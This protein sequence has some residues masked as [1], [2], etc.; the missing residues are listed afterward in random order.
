MIKYSAT[1]ASGGTE[2]MPYLFK[3]NI[4]ESIE[5]CAKNGFDAVELHLRKAQDIDRVL[6]KEICDKN[7]IAVSTIGTGMGYTLDR[8]YLTNS[9]ESKRKDAIERLKEHIDLASFF[10]CAVIIGS[11]RGRLPDAG[12]TK[13]AFK[14]YRESL[15]ALAHYAE[16]RDVTLLIEP[17]NRYESN[18]HNTSIEMRDFIK[19]LGSSKL[20]MLLD[21]FHMNIEEFGKTGMYDSIRECREVLGHM[22]FADSNRKRPGAGHIDFAGILKTLNDIGYDK[23]IALECLP[24][25][26]PEHASIDGLRYIKSLG[27]GG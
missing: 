13:S 14:N 19:S 18:F 2:S 24:W 4:I 22:H 15:M 9:D 21:T 12:E 7:S 26:E 6:V 11:M 20:K 27:N 23:Y 3:G 1:I 17:V 5:T 25:P 10:K 16:K 8:L